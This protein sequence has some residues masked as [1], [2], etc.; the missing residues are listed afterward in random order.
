MYL[1]ANPV[2][3]VFSVVNCF[4]K[5][6][7]ALKNGLRKRYKESRPEYLVQSYFYF[8]KRKSLQLIRLLMYPI[9][10]WPRVF[11]VFAFSSIACK[12][13]T[14]GFFQTHLSPK[15]FLISFFRI[16]T[17]GFFCL[18]I[19][20]LMFPTL[21]SFLAISAAILLFLVG[22]GLGSSSSNNFFFL[23]THVLFHFSPPSKFVPFKFQVFAQ[24]ST[25]KQRY[26]QVCLDILN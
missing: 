21:D 7:V 2:I 11:F 18:N 5:K 10:I 12:S 6:T 14:L 16:S 22:R 17:S 26:F 9:L 4:I 20:S 3:F 19:F 25:P 1:V 24:E 13:S 15:S 8:P 23:N